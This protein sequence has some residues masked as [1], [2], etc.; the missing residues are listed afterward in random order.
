MAQAV[1]KRRKEARPAELLD[2]AFELFVERGFAATRIDD[3]AARAGVSKGTVYL[4]FPSKQAVFEALV[5]QAVLPN[6]ERLIGETARPGMPVLEILPR[7]L[8]AIMRTVAGS[9]LLKFPRLIIAESP[10]FPELAQ[11]W[12]ETVID[13]MLGVVSGLIERG[14]A[15]GEIRP[16]D[17]ADTA[18]LMIAPLLMAV[19]WGTTFVKEGE[20]FDLNVFIDRHLDIY[21]RGLAAEVQS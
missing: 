18:R 6:L 15:A 9:P 1:R 13:R 3:I 12:R 10:Q 16:V 21:L 17:P 19:I 5:R 2:A 11:F 14:I 7:L 8:R 4:Y 20:S